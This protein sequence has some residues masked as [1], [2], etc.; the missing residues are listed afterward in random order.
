MIFSSSTH[1][2]KVVVIGGGTGSFIVL[3]A[4]RDYPVRLSSIVSMADSGGSTGKLRDQYGVLP[5]GD[6]R[7]SLVALI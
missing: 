4:L 5:P 7:R 2:K 3:S 1:N 6:I